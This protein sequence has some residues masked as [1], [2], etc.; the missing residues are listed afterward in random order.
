M[1]PKNLVR[2][3]V[4]AAAMGLLG[5]MA[6]PANAYNGGQ[7]ASYANS[8][9]INRNTYWLVFSND[10]TNFISQ[11]MH[12]GGLATN[13]E[14][15]SI[16]SDNY[17]TQT[18]SVAHTSFTWITAH[19]AST[20]AHLSAAQGGGNTPSWHVPGDPVYYDWEN[21]GHIDHA[22]MNVAT[23]TDPQYPG[24][25]GD[26]IDEHTTNRLKVIWNLKPYNAKYA[27]TSFYLDHI[28]S[29]AS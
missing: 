2:A 15:S 16:P 22:S 17:W 7:A 8:Y 1:R 25:V 24:W 18:W 12:A 19:K 21:D 6:T 27:I 5:V 26:L 13:V 28:P 29:S 14:W 10:C 9:A 4:V 20:S 23:G 11:A 3:S